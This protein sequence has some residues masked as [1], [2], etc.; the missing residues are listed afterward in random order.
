MHRWYLSFVSEEDVFLGACVLDADEFK[1]A[2]IKSHVLAINPGGQVMGMLV[3]DDARD[4][5][6]LNRLMSKAEL[7]SY[8]PIK[9]LGDMDKPPQKIGMN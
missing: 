7:A 6:P 5:L 8:G 2:L 1:D 9:R 3:P 4:N